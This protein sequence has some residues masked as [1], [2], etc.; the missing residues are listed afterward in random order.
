MCL[1]FCR[2]IEEAFDNGYMCITWEGSR[3]A[4]RLEGKYRMHWLGDA[5]L[6]IQDM[7]NYP[8]KASAEKL[9]TDAQKDLRA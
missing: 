3:G 9:P 8:W 6:L 1:P 5:E 4:D 2:P 7:T